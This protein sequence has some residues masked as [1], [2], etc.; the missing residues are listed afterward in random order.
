STASTWQQINIGGDLAVI[1]AEIGET[2]RAIA[3]T[4]E[5]MAQAEARGMRWQARVFL[6]NLAGVLHRAGLFA[7]TADMARRAADLAREAG[8]PACL[9]TALSLRA[10]ALR[11]TG[12][13]P[14]ALSSVDE[15][16]QLQRTWANRIRALTLL[17]RA[18][19]LCAMER[20]DEAIEDA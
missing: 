20:M 4:H 1:E 10:D 15:A 6:Q 11:Q 16:E 7:E 13:L 2:D 8:D 19:I 3:R 5:L 17:R 18:Q 14:A 9:S 12:D